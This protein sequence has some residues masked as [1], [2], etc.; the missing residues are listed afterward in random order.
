MFKNKLKLSIAGVILSS[1]FSAQ[2][3]LSDMQ[4]FFNDI[5]VY[6]NAQAPSAFQ[7][8]TRNYLTGGSLNI[9]VPN[10]NYQLA[11]FDPPRLGVGA[12]GS[13]DAYAGAFS[14]LNSDQLVQML[15]NIGNNAAG[16]VFSLA[17]E[18]VSPELNAVMKYFQD[19]ASKINSRNINSCHVATGIVTAA[20]DGKL[21]G[22]MKT[23][24]HQFGQDFGGLGDDWQA[25]TD[26]FKQSGKEKQALDA[27]KTSSSLS[28]DE[29]M[30]LEPG[31]LLWKAL[32]RLT[33]DGTGFSDD[34]KLLIQSLVGTVII[35]SKQINGKE[36]QT[37]DVI[38]PLIDP[39][40]SISLFMGDSDSSSVSV[41]VYD[42]SDLTNCDTVTLGSTIKTVTPMKYIV[43]Q[44]IKTLSDKVMNRTGGI[45]AADY[46]IVNISYLPVWT[47]IENEYRTDG[48]LGTLNNSEDV[49]ATSYLRALLDRVFNEVH[50]SLRAFKANNSNPGITSAI[51]EYE[52]NIDN[53]RRAV[54]NAAADQYK[55]FET[56]M[57]AKKALELETTRVQEQTAEKLN[58]INARR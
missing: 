55:K 26:S 2:A 56:Y 49:I 16:A 25:M 22:Y 23:S 40:K 45:T 34:E 30:W 13:I 11:T 50:R 5:G 7:G 24:L 20:K 46:Q 31:N 8:Q 14:F 42:C 35:K 1:S 44:R 15:Q 28:A 21:D 54:S 57:A 12:C 6:G 18:S 47:M 53:A 9:R 41:P 36:K 43:H 58:N 3:G 38:E 10:K 51:K 29:K 48:I 17:L 19:L 37:A 4:S 39:N 32:G 33:V 52:S 27:A